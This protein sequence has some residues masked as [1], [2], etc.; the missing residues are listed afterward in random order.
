MVEF[1]GVFLPIVREAFNRQS[2][3]TILP[4]YA[5]FL[6]I[7][8][9]YLKSYFK[10]IILPVLDI[11]LSELE[12]SVAKYNLNGSTTIPHDLETIMLLNSLAKLFRFSW[13]ESTWGALIQPL[14]QG[15]KLNESSIYGLRGL[16]DM[17][18]G[19][20]TGDSSAAQQCTPE[21]L[22]KET[23]FHEINR[24]LS[25]L[26]A[27]W[28][29]TSADSKVGDQRIQ[30]NP[31]S[32]GGAVESVQD[33][34]NYDALV[35]AAIRIRRQ[36][37]RLMEEFFDLS[38]NVLVECI[39]IQWVDNR[40]S[41][42]PEAQDCVPLDILESIRGYQPKAII[43]CILELIKER[44]MTGSSLPHDRVCSALELP[45]IRLAEAQLLQFL[46]YYAGH[47]TSVEALVEVYPQIL[48]L[49]KD[50]LSQPSN[51]KSS[52][53][54]LLKAYNSILTRLP[55][56]Y[57]ED[58]RFKRETYDAYQKLIDC[59][60]WIAG[61]SFDTG[62][63]RKKDMTDPMNPSDI[64]IEAISRLS[65][66]ISVYGPTGAAQQER[67]QERLIRQITSFFADKIVPTLRQLIN[68][69]DRWQTILTSMI[70]YIITPNLKLRAKYI[71]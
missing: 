58:K 6:N 31:G 39:A 35:S 23:L 42:P 19:V 63:W 60:T 43:F 14:N 33:N 22:L 52:L 26:K 56:S 12:I 34:K 53:L 10:P 54:Y 41:A 36:M 71:Y 5:D 13:L 29:C 37:V 3:K 61:R 18:T 44:M 32:S 68:E 62:L 64:T 1:A 27:T 4:Y 21:Q 40:Q 48:T 67:N 7:T 65:P 30:N 2:N 50:Y 16:T 70:Y 28:L 57:V 59:C 25:V 8:I 55:S 45:N 24:A 9:P 46:A 51:F 69:P 49:I 17:V 66:E 38:S 15:R 47:R 11:V 20:F